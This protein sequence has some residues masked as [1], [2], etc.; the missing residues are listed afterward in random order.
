M[1]FHSIET[2]I[3]IFASGRIHVEVKSTGLGEPSQLVDVTADVAESGLVAELVAAA[4][5]KGFVD[6]MA[7]EGKTR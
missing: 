1:R 5:R 6:L 2:R 7:R 3:E 4:V